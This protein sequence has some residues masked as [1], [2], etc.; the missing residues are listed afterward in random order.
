M[1]V[2][3]LL[4]RLRDSSPGSPLPAPL[5]QLY[6]GGLS[7]PSPRCYVNFV[8][9]VD[10]VVAV[11][12][13]RNSG[14][15]ISGRNR[16]DRFLM[17]L[18]RAFADAVL[19]GAGTV[20]AEGRNARWT[21]DF[22][23]P[24]AAAGFSQ[25]RAEL[26]L[27]PEPRLAILTASGELDPTQ[28]VLEAG[29]IV[30]APVRAASTLRRTLPSTCEVVAPGGEDQVDLRLAVD[31]LRERGLRRILSEGGPSTFGELLRRRLVDEL[32]LTVSPVLA[33]REEGTDRLGL[34]E[35]AR[36]PAGSFPSMELCSVRRS[37]SHLFLRYLLVNDTRPGAVQGSTA[38]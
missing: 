29:A 25:L 4:E 27:S 5:E 13:R 8:T 33:G 26:K 17:G 38:R 21:P 20:R 7:I 15:V 1:T 23:Y 18:L 32:F 9:S 24:D 37:G 34:V 16:A 28:P 12:E 31:A 3:P 11:E 19:V 14:S 2:T 6:D 30:L 22:V 35:R 10:G 36:F